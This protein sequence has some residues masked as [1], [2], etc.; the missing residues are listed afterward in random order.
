MSFIPP[1]DQLCGLS[2]DVAELFGKP[3]FEAHYRTRNV[4]SNTLDESAVCIICGNRAD[5]SHHVVPL[6]KAKEFILRTEN[7][8]FFLRSPLFAVCGSGT[9]KCHNDFH[10]GARY[11][12]KWLWH[13]DRFAEQWWSGEISKKILPHSQELYQFGYWAIRDKFVGKLL[14]FDGIDFRVQ[15][16]FGGAR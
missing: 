16:G 15:T 8:V 14:T 10:G 6:G 2:L 3:H 11:S 1:K 12:A 4:K 5:N 7:G 13:N 9:T